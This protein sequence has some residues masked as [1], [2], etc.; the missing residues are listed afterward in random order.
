MWTTNGPKKWTS[1]GV[2]IFKTNFNNK[3]T[4]KKQKSLLYQRLHSHA[5]SNIHICACVQLVKQSDK[6]AKLENKTDEI[7]V[8]VEMHDSD[9]EPLN[10]II[11]LSDDVIDIA[12]KEESVKTEIS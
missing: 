10:K 2:H 6:Y 8:K 1:E 12:C 5:R 11:K 3:Q 9:D 4:E 7:E